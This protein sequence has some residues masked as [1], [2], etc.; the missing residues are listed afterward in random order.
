MARFWSTRRILARKRPL[1]IADARWSEV[2]T[3]RHYLDWNDL[4]D[5]S[6]SVGC[7]CQGSTVRTMGSRERPIERLPATIRRYKLK[8]T[9]SLLA[10][11]AGGGAVGV[12]LSEGTMHH[13]HDL[14]LYALCSAGGATAE[15]AIERGLRRRGQ[16]RRALALT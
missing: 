5:G 9:G 14:G 1:W 3:G 12:F 11:A 10:Y 4:G 6:L 7:P 16:R 2:P 15:W 8:V 13:P